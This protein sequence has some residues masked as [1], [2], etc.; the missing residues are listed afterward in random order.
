MTAA[1]ARAGGRLRRTAEQL[2]SRLP[3]LAL[4]RRQVAAL[5]AAGAHGRRR[6]GPGET[7]WQFRRYRP[8]DAAAA[9]D[10]RAS[11]RTHRLYVRETEW[12][13]AESVWLWVDASLSMRFASR[14]G[15]ATKLER[16]RLLAMAAAV[17]LVHGGESVALLGQ[18]RRPVPGRAALSRLAWQLAGG[19]DDGNGDGGDGGAE[20]AGL[21][22]PQPLPRHARLLL[23]GDFLEPLE[24]LDAV[25]RHFAGRGAAGHMLQVLDPA[26]EALPYAGRVAFAGLEGEGS[27]LA[28]RAQDLAA[29]YAARLAAHRD[30]LAR[31]ARASRWTFAS[32]RSDRPALPALLA[33]HIALAGQ[34][35]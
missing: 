19:G 18:A 32:H 34:A 20:A 10:W 16:A 11:A 27:F 6:V 4:A 9:I 17:L 23:V 13:A 35:A 1:A 3:P 5:A 22:A 33:L 7:F 26:E 25:I 29:D 31:L 8:G 14:P 24:N 2:A 21:P 12:A 28:G 15:L 30:E